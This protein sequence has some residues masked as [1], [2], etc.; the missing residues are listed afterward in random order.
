MGDNDPQGSGTHAGSGGVGRYGRLFRAGAFVRRTEP[1]AAAG[2][3]VFKAALTKNHELWT[4]LKR[5]FLF[6]E[7]R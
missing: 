4:F 2:G 7:E 3:F 1:G 5:Q 6:T